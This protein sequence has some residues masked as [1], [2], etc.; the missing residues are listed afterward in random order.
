MQ[1]NDA[2]PLKKPVT[3]APAPAA[4]NS[5][6]T[7]KTNISPTVVVSDNVRLSKP[8]KELAA[9]ASTGVFDSKKVA[10]I[11]AAIADGTFKIDASKIAT[12]L[13]DSVKELNQRS[14]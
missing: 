8:A 1:I 3:P 12:G 5:R 14:R 7:E 13:I 2:G 11:K 4:S 10:E 9:G 6:A